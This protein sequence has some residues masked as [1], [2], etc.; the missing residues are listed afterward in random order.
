M[1]R[2]ALLMQD[3]ANDSVSMPVLVAM[4]QAIENEALSRYAGLA[5][6]MRRRGETATA[7]AFESMLEEE[8]E[9]A[10]WI[11]RWA[12]SL[13]A[14][15][16][17]P[18]R[19]D[20][21]LPPELANSWD[22]IVGSALLTPYRAFAIAADNEM[23]AFALYSYLAARADDATVRAQAEQ[24]GIEQLH[25]AAVMRRWRRQAW[26]RERATA[27]ESNATPTPTSVIDSAAAL[28]ALIDRHEAGI[29][30][31]HAALSRR[32]RELGAQ[33]EA[34]CLDDVAAM[35]P[36]A[37]SGTAGAGVGV[38]SAAISP[39][40]QDA[41]GYARASTDPVHLLVAA[42]KPLEAFS[43]ALEDAMRHLEGALFERAEAALANVVNRLGRLALQIARSM[44]AR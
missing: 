21:Q 34:R 44:H 33:A 4:T 9:H 27:D 31:V 22:E 15:S 39:A 14:R 19:F 23:R 18:Q 26:H 1:Q 24:L 38:G 10:A 12:A 37:T 42:Q 17:G 43:E 25:R 20:W 35:A 28:Q 2:A 13:P 6:A 40:D 5:Q 11:A 3:P 32:L 36:E 16:T 41:A 29:A 30:Q 8:H 7:M